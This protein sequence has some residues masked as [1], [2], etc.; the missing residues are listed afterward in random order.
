MVALINKAVDLISK[1]S[2]GETRTA[3]T[4]LAWRIFR[5]RF[6]GHW[7]NLGQPKV[8]LPHLRQVQRMRQ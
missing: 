8:F 6:L 4:S 2:A 7:L 5:L 1:T 3:E